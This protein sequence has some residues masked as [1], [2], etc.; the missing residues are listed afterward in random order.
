MIREYPKQPI[1][2]VGVVVLHDDKI[3][4]AR[5]SKPPRAGDWS[6]PG[7]AQNLGETI[8][9]TALREIK[10][11]TGLDIKVL[12]IVDVVDSII[13]DGDGRVQYHYTLVD[14]FAERISGEA[15]AS[16]DAAE[17]G[18]FGLDE[19]DSLDLWSETDRIIR[20]AHEMWSDLRV[21]SP[22]QK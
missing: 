4:L 2:G 17:I 12:G 20:L 14:V 3:L 21:S 13:R 18:W 6:L 5:R 22:S 7:G 15:I 8:T 9:E 16:D 1:A 10:E 11:E 19:L